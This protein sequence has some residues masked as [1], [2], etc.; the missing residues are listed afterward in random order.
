MLDLGLFQFVALGLTCAWV[1]ISFI[2]DKKT[3]TSVL[4]YALY[5]LGVIL[6]E[7]GQ[8]IFGTILIVLGT[9]MLILF[10]LIYKNEHN[11]NSNSKKKKDHNN[12]PIE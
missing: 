8:A 3:G 12:G 1:V 10:F 2:L 11:W 6:F 5:V 9:C 4:S 7:K